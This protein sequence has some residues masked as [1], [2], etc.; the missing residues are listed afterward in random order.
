MKLF[1]WDFHGVLEK[2]NELAVLEISNKVLQ[3]RGY[4]ER[5][6]KTDNLKLY[7][8]KWYQYFEYLLPHLSKKDHLALQAAC[9]DYSAKNW[10]IRSKYIKPNDHELEVLAAIK[11]AGHD[12]IVLSNTRPAA[13]RW[14][15]QSVKIDQFFPEDKAFGVN[16][17]QTKGSKADSL[18]K[19]LKGEKID[20]IVIVGDSEGD[21]NLKKIAGGTTYFYCHPYLATSGQVKADHYITDLRKVLQ[22]L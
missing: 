8:L 1:V 6:T 16:A 11:K 17:H 4:K 12:Q 5:F 13:L 14:F 19:Y 9:L 2:D 20:A 21:M 3:L 22:E 10:H 18:K 15:L 7:G